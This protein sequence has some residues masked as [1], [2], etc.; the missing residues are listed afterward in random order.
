WMLAEKILAAHVG[1]GEGTP[2]TRPLEPVPFANAVPAPPELVEIALNPE[3]LRA[4]VGA[5]EI[6]PG[7]TVV[8]T[9]S[10]DRLTAAMPGAPD[11]DIFPDSAKTFFAKAA[12]VRIKFELDGSGLVSG[13]VVSYR[14]QDLAA[15]RKI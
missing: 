5:Y 9:L 13:L 15:R 3:A 6:K 1:P 10:G 14:G 12:P 7:Q 8:I 4:F 2:D 11:L